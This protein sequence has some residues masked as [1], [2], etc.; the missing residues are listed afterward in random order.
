MK[1]NTDRRP[2]VTMTSEM[3]GLKWP[4]EF[5]TSSL[6][7]YLRYNQPLVLAAVY[8]VKAIA[9][10]HPMLIWIHWLSCFLDRSNWHTTPMPMNWKTLP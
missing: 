1:W 3:A 10:P 9:K 8:T 4:P 2:N 7:N 6:S 5:L